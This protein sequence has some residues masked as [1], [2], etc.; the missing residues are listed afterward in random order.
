MAKK[1]ARTVEALRHDE[2]KRKNVPTAEYQ[3]VVQKEAES[4]VRVA[5]ERRNREAGTTANEQVM[6]KVDEQGN[7]LGFSVMR[8]SAV[9]HSPLEVALS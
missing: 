2:A 7:V 9:R 1:S 3:S 5:Y 4:P 6:E 8:V